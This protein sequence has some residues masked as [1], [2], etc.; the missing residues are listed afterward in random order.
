MHKNLGDG[1]IVRCL[2]E[3]DVENLLEFVKKVFGH[4]VSPTVR[5]LLDHFPN[6]SYSDNF[7]V[8]DTNLNKILAYLCLL[9]FSCVFCGIEIP[10]GQMEIVGTDPEYRHRRFISKLNKVFEKRAAEYNLP[11]LIIA[12]IPYFYRQFGYE[13]AIPLRDS[14]TI[15]NDVIPSLKKGEPESFSI[16]RVTKDLF[17]EYLNLREKRNALFDLYRKVELKNWQYLSQGKL[18]EVG[19]KELYLIKNNEKVIGSFY[20]DVL[21]EKLE[22]KE[23]WLE[24]V[25]CIPTILRF[26]S[27]IAREKDIPLGVVPP[28]QNSLISYFERLVGLKF[29]R[30]YAC[31]VKVPSVSKFLEIIKPVLK[32]RLLGSEFSSL[33]KSLRLSFY[34]EGFEMV[35]QNG[36]LVKIKHL[37]IKELEDM[38]INIPPLV[39]F[40]LLLGYRTVEELENIYPDVTVKDEF[41][42]VIKILFP[43]VKASFTPTL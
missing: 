17:Q 5:R 11:F 41:K 15:S 19:A 38:H 37:T 23:L 27:I 6:F 16:I 30:P 20:I 22:I 3:S 4:D 8:F 13:Y 35:F 14:L 26:C 36:E 10:F 34:R 39:N 33:T 24:S 21:F 12:G 32:M 29:P 31:Y 25:N 7:V 18:G 9:R 42:P 28:V 43:K 1:I 40:Q 2:Q